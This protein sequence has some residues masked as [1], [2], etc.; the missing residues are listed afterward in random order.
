MATSSSSSSSSSFFVLPAAV[1]SPSSSSSSSSTREVKDKP[2]V[3]YELIPDNSYLGMRSI[4]TEVTSPY[5]RNEIKNCDRKNKDQMKR[6]D[7]L[8]TIEHY[9]LT[10]NDSMTYDGLNIPHFSPHHPSQLVEKYYQKEYKQMKLEL[11]GSPTTSEL[12]NTTGVVDVFRA[13]EE[14]RERQITATK[15]KIF[16]ELQ[17]S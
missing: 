12:D 4:R 16:D 17:K 6:I 9:I 2:K 3:K 1:A 10:G 15:N 5:L 11:L 13:L 8:R 7:H 14:E